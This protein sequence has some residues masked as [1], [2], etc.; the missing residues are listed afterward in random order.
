MSKLNLNS[1][2]VIKQTVMSTAFL[3]IAA[4]GGGGGGG[5]SPNTP[6]ASKSLWPS[7]G[8]YEVVLK[9]S[10][11]LTANPLQMTL[12][13]VH[14][15]TP[16]TE[17]QI[18]TSA[19]ATQLG[20]S[21]SQ[22]Q[23]NP[24]KG[25]FTDLQNV[26]YIDHRN[27][28]VRVTSL[29]AN[30]ARPVQS[31]APAADLCSTNQLAR[32]F[33]KPFASQLIVDTPGPDG[34]CNSS[35]DG[36][37]LVTFSDVGVPSISTVSSNYRYLGYLRSPTTGQPTHWLVTWKNGVQIELWSIDQPGTTP[38]ESSVSTGTP[39]FS[40]V[41]N[42]SDL[43]LYTQDGLLKAMRMVNGTP[44]ISNV[45]ALSGTSGWELAGNDEANAYAFFSTNASTSC[46]GSWH[47][48]KISRSAASAETLATGK[49]SLI[50]ATALNGSIYA[51]V[52][53]GNTISLKKVDTTTGSITALKASSSTVYLASSLSGEL[54]VTS[55]S[56]TNGS[57]SL[58]FLDNSDNLLY[59]AGN[60]IVFGAN[61]TAYISS[62][63]TFKG[64]SVYVVPQSLITT[65][66]SG[67]LRRWDVAS[68]A[69]HTVGTL[70]SAFELGGK[71]GIRV[72]TG[73]LSPG[74]LI[75]GTFVAS[76]SSDGQV[77]TSGSRVYTLLPQTDNSLVLTT[78]QVK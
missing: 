56:S 20:V 7:S 45:S 73:P 3:L 27:G 44:S 13:L 65:G 67:T 30:G 40:S 57:L 24:T 35:D 69:M 5:S 29:L 39:Q 12:S 58:N 17:Y 75:G 66:S 48:T 38:I 14:A 2:S 47:I 74:A 28:A 62:N 33:S 42:L 50:A 72:F 52:C 23:W 63:N 6:D 78:K 1:T 59:D 43:I 22:G 34:L 18:D 68:K 71:N 10:G 21:L 32:N 55:I 15:S 60:D 36:Q 70:P 37:I 54:T 25:Q 61:Q 49:G 11:S 51:S 53:S 9:P 26:A 76:I 46:T 77:Q 31:T 41:A 8:R 4:C 19:A 16:E 64:E